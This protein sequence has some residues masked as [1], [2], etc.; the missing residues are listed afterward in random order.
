MHVRP[1][2]QKKTIPLYN[3]LT[4]TT[5]ACRYLRLLEP[6]EWILAKVEAK[7]GFL[8][9]RIPYYISVENRTE[10]NYWEFLPMTS[11]M[12]P[13]RGGAGVSVASSSSPAPP[14]FTAA[15]P[16]VRLGS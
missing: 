3:I 11:S 10:V 12:R 2:P 9:R 6:S 7:L 1:P 5:D 8:L 15:G 4:Q 14:A 16:G 13:S